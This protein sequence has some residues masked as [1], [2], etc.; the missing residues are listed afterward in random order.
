MRVTDRGYVERDLIMGWL[1]MQGLQMSTTNVIKVD[2][3]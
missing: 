1:R 3:A 2:Y